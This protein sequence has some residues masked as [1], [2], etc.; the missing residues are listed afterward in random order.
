MFDSYAR[1]SRMPDTGE[2]EKIETQWADNRKVVE[3]L[4][5]VLGAELD[6]GLSAWKKTSHVA[7][8]QAAWRCGVV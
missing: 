8:S 1:L 6:D 5:G 2:L 7:S 4:G 3:R